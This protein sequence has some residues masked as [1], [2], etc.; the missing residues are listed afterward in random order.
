M[1]IG[2][3]HDLTSPF[4]RRAR[5]V[6]AN[7]CSPGRLP[8]VLGVVAL[9]LV[10]GGF[11]VGLLSAPPLKPRLVHA[12]PVPVT[13]TVGST[14]GFPAPSFWGTNLRVHA[15][16]GPYDA[17]RFNQT[18]NTWVRWPGGATGDA[19]NMTANEIR[20][21]SGGSY[22]PPQTAAEFVTWCS[23][24]HCHAIVELPAEINDSSTAAYEVRYL[25]DSLGFHPN[26][27]EIGNEP[28]AWRHFNHPWTGWSS[29][30]SVNATPFQYA[31]VV[32]EYVS[33]IRAVDARAKIIGLPGV[34]TGSSGETAWIQNVVA[35]NGATID[36]VAVHTYPAGTG[37]S[38]STLADFYASLDGPGSLTKKIPA[39]RAQILRACPTCGSMPIFSTETS[40]A[41]DGGA[42]DALMASEAQAAYMMA[43]TIEGLALNLSNLDYFAY[44]STFHGAW[45]A[46][47]SHRSSMR[48]VFALYSYMFNNSSF[49]RTLGASVAPA[50]GSLY[51][52]VEENASQTGRTA[53]LMA[54]NVDTVTAY[55]LRLTDSG[56]ATTR[57]ATVF[58]WDASTSA[59]TVTTYP[60]GRMP[61]SFTLQ[62][63]GILEVVT[64]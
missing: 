6:R 31:Y 63:Q 59:P 28:A 48:P 37:S 38:G 23:W 61:S 13:L 3:D 8:A 58:Y 42:Y 56:F 49:G 30:D 53:T 62:P 60:A 21:D 19:F 17:Y 32:K 27:W 16:L 34:G 18:V 25:E 5:R 50:A 2:S 11:T 12:V 29:N 33:A 4:H 44:V 10:G 15:S 47:N 40:S 14:L 46:D 20:N 54:A 26:Y 39:D 35:Y 51:T 36:A 9:L 57:A 24:I 22:R 55:S 41:N 43:E 1:Q 7:P 45:F 52:I 64:A